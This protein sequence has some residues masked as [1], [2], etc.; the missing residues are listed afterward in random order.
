M[1][2]VILPRVEL[3][4]FVKAQFPPE[5]EPLP[6]PRSI[7]L[8]TL[9][10][11][12]GACALFI[13]S[14]LDLGYLSMRLNPCICIYTLLYHVGVVF[15][16]RRR[17]TPEAP[18][19]FSTIVFCGYL[20]AFIWFVALIVTIVVLAT[21]DHT[22]YYQV[23][24]LQQQGLPV[25]VHSQRAQVFLTLYETIAVGGMALKAHSIVH[26]EG[27]DPHDWRYMER[28]KGDVESVFRT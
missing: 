4:A 20:L 14:M 13:V 11:V 27:P 26:H 5:T 10:S 2:S 24:W 16:G 17:R 28:E 22:P 25:T 18:S 3:P 23:V 21:S 15:I 8:I 9:A 12:P 7:V 6:V 19:Y 1:Q